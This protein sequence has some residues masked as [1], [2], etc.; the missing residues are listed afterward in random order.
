MK[1]MVT[2]TNEKLSHTITYY[3]EGQLG[4]ICKDIRI[5]MRKNDWDLFE[6]QEYKGKWKNEQDPKNG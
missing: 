3:V 2:L 4:K 6:V 5:L 1:Y